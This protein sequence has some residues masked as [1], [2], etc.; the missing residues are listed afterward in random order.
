MCGGIDALYFDVLI[1]VYSTK[2]LSQFLL[3]P[4][5]SV[6]GRV[7]EGGRGHGDCALLPGGED[8]CV[9]HGHARHQPV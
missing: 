8:E 5:G 2:Q 9:R 4:V 1:F 3:P 7:R 6:Q